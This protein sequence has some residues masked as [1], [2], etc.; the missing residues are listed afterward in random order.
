M[1]SSAAARAK[2]RCGIF[3]LLSSLA[4]SCL[5]CYDEATRDLSGVL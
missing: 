4:K 1:N 2:P 5:L 3:M